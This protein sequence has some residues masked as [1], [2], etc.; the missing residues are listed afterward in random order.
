MNE[1]SERSP[2]DNVLTLLTVAH[3]LRILLYLNG[4]LEDIVAG[5]DFAKGGIEN[6]TRLIAFFN[7]Q[8][9][10]KGGL[11][12]AERPN[13]QIVHLADATNIEEC[14]VHLLH[15]DALWNALHQHIENVAND[16]KGGEED[17]DREEKG[18]DWID[19]VVLGKKV[20]HQ[21]SNEHAQTLEKVTKNVDEGGTY[22]DVALSLVGSTG[23]TI[24]PLLHVA[25]TVSRMVVPS[26]SAVTVSVWNATKC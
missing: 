19:N 22:V 6:L 26:A 16:G 17:N 23:E 15:V 18:T 25:V 20:N 13:A 10:R 5:L 12:K 9:R 7:S 24:S 8:M 2:S 11:V 3:L 4:Q 21:R 14:L 1:S